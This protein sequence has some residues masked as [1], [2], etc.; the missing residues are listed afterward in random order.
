MVS[1]LLQRSDDYGFSDL[2]KDQAWTDSYIVL[3]ER[4]VEKQGNMPVFTNGKD[5]RNYLI[6][7]C[8]LQAGSLQRKYMQKDDYIE[9]LPQMKSNHENEE[10][11]EEDDGAISFVEEYYPSAMP[12]GEAFEPDIN[13][14]NPYEVAHAVSIILLNSSHPL[15]KALTDGIEDKAGILIDKAVNGMS[16]NDIISEQYGEETGFQEHLETCKA[17]RTY[18]NF[19]RRLSCLIADEELAYSE[20]PVGRKKKIRLWSFV[21]I[22]ACIVLIAGISLYVSNN[23]TQ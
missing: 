23:G 7:V 3:R 2:I 13:T 10:D 9:D 6:K 17:C 1:Y 20:R 18:V 21:S 14:G 8:K 12:E 19:I 4:L 22:A 11:R 16:Y 5:F 15:H